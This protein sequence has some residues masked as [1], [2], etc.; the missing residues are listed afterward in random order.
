MRFGH[1]P[2]DLS[3]ICLRY[4]TANIVYPETLAEIVSLMYIQDLQNCD[5]IIA[6]DDS[7]LRELL[8]PDKADVAFRYSLAHAVVKRRR[9]YAHQ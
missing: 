7:V 3:H 5:E 9:H 2:N 6:G 1:S 4:A 8:H